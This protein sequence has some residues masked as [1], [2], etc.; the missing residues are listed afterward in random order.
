MIS[1]Y[2]LIDNYGALPAPEITSVGW[3]TST[4]RPDFSTNRG[5]GYLFSYELKHYHYHLFK[6]NILF[7]TSGQRISWFVV[8]PN[9]KCSGGT[10][11]Q[12]FKL[13]DKTWILF[14]KFNICTHLMR[15][16]RLQLRL[17]V[18]QKL[19]LPFLV[20]FLLLIVSQSLPQMLKS[21]FFDFRIQL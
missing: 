18:R 17:W 5:T 12:Q 14:F 16:N 8:S 19:F 1:C 9:I 21:Y 2:Q 15:L 7:L 4:S 3:K 13:H 10:I 6:R 11:W 20:I